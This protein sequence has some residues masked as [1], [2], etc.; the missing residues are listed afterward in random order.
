MIS[1]FRFGRRAKRYNRRART[2]KVESGVTAEELK[3]IWS[4]WTDKSKITHCIY[5]DRDIHYNDSRDKHRDSG[6]H[7]ESVNGGGPSKARNLA[8]AC[9]YCNSHK[10]GE[11]LIEWFSQ[12]EFFTEERLDKIIDST[13]LIDDEGDIKKIVEEDENLEIPKGDE[14]DEK[15]I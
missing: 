7:L 3:E 10:G 8:P 6:E 4:F 1:L 12:Q 5:C 13:R 2:K 11:D 14:E 15:E 9:A